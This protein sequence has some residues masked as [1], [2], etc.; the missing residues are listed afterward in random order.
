MSHSKHTRRGKSYPINAWAPEGKRYVH[1]CSLCGRKGFDPIAITGQ[2]LAGWVKDELQTILEPIN[3][4]VAGHCADC[5]RI[6]RE[7]ARGNRG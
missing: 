3:I 1:G 6:L 4:D 7:V 2:S 5:S